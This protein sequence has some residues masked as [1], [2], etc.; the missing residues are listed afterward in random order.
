MITY[1]QNKYLTP[2]EVSIRWGGAVNLSTLANWRSRK[3]NLPFM[4][5]GG[6]VHYKLSDI[7]SF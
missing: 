5:F 7:E 2:E 3:V 1:L 4:K 6:K